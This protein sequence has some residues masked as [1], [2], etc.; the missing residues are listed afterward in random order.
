MRTNLI[1]LLLIAG[2]MMAGCSEEN[3]VPAFTRIEAGIDCGVAPLTVQFNAYATG[4]NLSDSPTGGNSYL[5]F[6]WDFDDGD[7][8]Q[9]STTNH[10][11]DE[12]GTYTVDVTVTDDDGDGET[13]F[14]EIIVLDDVMAISAKPDTTVTV[15]WVELINPSPSHPDISNSSNGT[16]PTGSLVINEI[17][18]HNTSA[19]EDP[20]YT[21]Q[22]PSWIEL[23][24]GTANDINLSGWFLSNDS[25]Y[26]ARWGF[27][28]NTIITANGFLMIMA[29]G[30]TN[31]SGLVLHANFELLPDGNWIDDHPE[32]DG[33]SE[34]CLSDFNRDVVDSRRFTP[35]SENISYGRYPDGSSNAT[36]QFNVD[37][38]MCGISQDSSYDRFDITWEMPSH[39]YDARAPWHTFDFND[40]GLNTIN[41]TVHDFQETN[42]RTD[43]VSIEILL[44][45]Q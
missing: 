26:P 31:P 18:V 6:R 24:N 42:T 22:Y 15:S 43:N 30:R 41:I 17:M 20:N 10:I 9:G 25:L 28:E 44:P 29:D 27:P 2:V 33:K 7:T 23:Y 8:A 3:L 4:G 19:F 32:W 39:T 1:F 11:F 37:V 40:A 35:T 12:P 21:G 14:K 45:Q 36:I 38:D 13:W 16:Y 5:N 34:V